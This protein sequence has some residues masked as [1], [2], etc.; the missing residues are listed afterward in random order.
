MV[1]VRKSI[2]RRS[3]GERARAERRELE[4]MEIVDSSN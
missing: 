4:V 1:L 2:Q 3:A